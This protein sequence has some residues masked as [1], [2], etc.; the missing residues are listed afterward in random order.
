MGFCYFSS[1]AISDL[2]VV[3]EKLSKCIFQVLRFF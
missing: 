1:T 3:I 2:T